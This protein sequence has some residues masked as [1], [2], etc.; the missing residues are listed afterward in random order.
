M[1]GDITYPKCIH[2]ALQSKLNRFSFNHRNTDL[3]SALAC[4]IYVR[5]TLCMLSVREEDRGCNTSSKNAQSIGSQKREDLRND[6]GTWWR[7]DGMQI[8]DNGSQAIER[9]CNRLVINALC[10]LSNN[11]HYVK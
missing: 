11:I 9:K 3:Q 2:N 6:R 10:R 5:D 1:V 4:D 8:G 7:S